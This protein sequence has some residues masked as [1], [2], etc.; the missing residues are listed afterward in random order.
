VD[1]RIILQK[2]K[3][4][5]CRMCELTC[6]VTKYGVFS[7]NKAHC[8]VPESEVLPIGPIFCRQCK[9]PLCRAACQ[10]DAFVE[11]PKTGVLSIDREKCV[12][13]M[14]CVDAC[15]FNAIFIDGEDGY[16]LKCDLCKGSPKCVEQCPF[17]ALTVK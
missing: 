16:P 1:M 3:C 15:P 5:G 4:T 6:S 11:D 9:K 14:K 13:C 17:G 12:R 8:K 7:T 2:D 10:Y